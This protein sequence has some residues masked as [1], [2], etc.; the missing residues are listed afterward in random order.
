MWGSLQI[1]SLS[2]AAKME[3]EHTS[4]TLQ[5]IYQPITQCQKPE[6]HTTLMDS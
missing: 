4:Q 5:P 6:D 3:V 1:L 2:S